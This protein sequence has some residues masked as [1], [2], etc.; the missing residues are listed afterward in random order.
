MRFANALKKI[1]VKKGDR[2][3]IY[4]PLVPEQVIAML[5]C[6]RIGAVHSVVFGGFG[7]AALNMRI[8][9]AEAKVVITADI[10][11]QAGKGY[12]AEI[13]RGRGHHQLI[14]S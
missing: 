11:H 12:P 5:A 6:A 13:N 4:M 10:R 3:C 7:A 9:D 14:I 8:Q 2:V 1:G